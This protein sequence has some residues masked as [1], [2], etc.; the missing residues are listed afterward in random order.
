MLLDGKHRN[1]ALLTAGLLAVS[2][3]V[4]V[5]YHLRALN[6][7]SGG[8]WVGLA[9][10]IAAFGLM[11]FAGLLGARRCVPAW[12]VGRPDAWMRGHL[13]L[14]LLTVP[15][16]FLHAG[17]RFGGTLTIVLMVLLVAVALSGIFGVV[18]Q[19][20]LPRVMTSRV[21][22]ETIYEQIGHVVGQLVAEADK[23]VSAVA[24]PLDYPL[25]G[26]EAAAKTAAP[27][28]GAGPLRDFYVGKV[29][30]FLESGRRGLPLA[31][32]ARAALAFPPVRALLPPPLHP[33][34]ADLEVICEERR[35]LATQARLHAWLHGWLLVHVPLSYA[36]LLLGAVH[37]FR[38]VRY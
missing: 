29:R 16:A 3:A 17:F 8:S 26:G 30:P 6:G 15:L 25:P 31:D 18:L 19:Q 11:V 4:Y 21:P 14:G 23:A 24:G 34:L 7:P 22:M 38:A 37:A 36:L 27:Q 35:Q 1:W 10:G 2:A 9:F 12:R 5:P 28:P 13:W 33:V 32:P 20:I